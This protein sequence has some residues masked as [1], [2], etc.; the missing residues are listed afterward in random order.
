MENDPENPE[1]AG[2]GGCCDG[3]AQGAGHPSEALRKRGPPPGQW[4]PQNSSAAVEH[5]CSKS[6]E[7]RVSTAARQGA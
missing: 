4:Q 3:R 2:P 5:W 1:P 6:H 7:L